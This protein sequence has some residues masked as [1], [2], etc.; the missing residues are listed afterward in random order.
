[1]QEWL[2]V[3]GY[4]DVIALQ[5]YGIHGADATLGTAS[6]TDHL[7]TLF[8]QSNRITTASDGGAAGQKA[9]RR[10]LHIALPTRSDG[11]ELKFFVLPADH[12]PD[13]LIRREGIENFRRLLDQAP[14][15]SDFV[16]AHLTQNQDITTPEGKSQVMGE[17]KN[18]TE[19]LPKHGS[20]RYL[21]Q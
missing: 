10:T 14:L 2:M 16:F 17:L 12:D 20:F 18:L 7:N 1:A 5:Q 13:S 21:L 15:M 11:R 9:A 3:E 6:T 4:M 19:L 8:K